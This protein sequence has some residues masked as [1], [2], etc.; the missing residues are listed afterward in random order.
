L[1]PPPFAVPSVAMGMASLDAFGCSSSADV[2]FRTQV[3]RHHSG[4]QPGERAR[5]FLKPSLPLHR[6]APRASQASQLSLQPFDAEV[7][8]SAARRGRREALPGQP[9]SWRRHLVRQPLRSAPPGPSPAGVAAYSAVAAQ[10]A[11]SMAV[12][13]A[14]PG[15]APQ[16]LCPSVADDPFGG[17]ESAE[18]IG[19]C[20]GGSS[21]ST[22]HLGGERRC[23]SV[24]ASSVSK[25]GFPFF[26]EEPDDHRV[27]L[28]AHRIGDSPP[29]SPAKAGGRG[30]E[31]S[32]GRQQQASRKPRVSSRS[33]SALVV[34]AK[35]KPLHAERGVGSAGSGAG[36]HP[37]GSPFGWL[38]E[39]AESRLPPSLHHQL[40][41]AGL[42][43]QSQD[44]G[45]PHVFEGHP[46]SMGISGP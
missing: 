44:S 41:C 12:L 45:A 39:N 46:T 23:R 9:P 22:G 3:L 10:C 38:R 11:L 30:R 7:E 40:R 37:P 4:P 19:L 13:P 15:S 20:L 32:P 34:G 21:S 8:E 24:R 36:V 14:T 27:H 17:P 25:A 18:E 29:R 26:S 31:A 33:S 43:Q 28:P 6:A 35:K 2:V 1:L 42:R 5:A 16:A